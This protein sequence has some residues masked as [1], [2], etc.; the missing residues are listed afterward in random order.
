W[1]YSTRFA[2]FC[3]CERSEAI[4]AG[5]YLY[6]PADRDCFG[7]L[8]GPRNDDHCFAAAIN[9]KIRCGGSGVWVMRTPNG[10]SASSIAPITAAAAG[11]VPTSPAPLAPSGLSGDGVCLN[12]VSITGTSVAPGSRYSAKVVV[13]GWPPAS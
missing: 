7:P 13:I 6:V 9:S 8:C 2:T 1:D 10:D 5:M 4:A 3:H 12:S 11:I